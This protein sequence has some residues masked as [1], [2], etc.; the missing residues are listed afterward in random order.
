[1]RVR[2]SD[3]ARLDNL[4]A[5]LQATECRVRKVDPATLDVSM[6][7][8]PSEEQAKREVDIYLRAWTAMNPGYHAGIVE[9]WEAPPA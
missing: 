3:G 5:F 1:M 7:R 9:S 6:L 4:I 2:V 8:V